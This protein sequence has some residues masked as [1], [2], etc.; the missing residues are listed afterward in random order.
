MTTSTRTVTPQPANV[1]L[2]TRFRGLY[3]G[4]PFTGEVV[5]QRGN[6][7][8]WPGTQSEVHLLIRVD[9]AIVDPRGFVR[10]AVGETIEMSCRW[11]DHPFG[12]LVRTDTRYSD[13]FIVK[14]F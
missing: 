13:L 14:Q 8:G 10:R 7:S 6:A 5:H 12:E 2:G 9:A 4:A 1:P 11:T 3:M